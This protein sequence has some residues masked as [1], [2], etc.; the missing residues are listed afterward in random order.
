MFVFKQMAGDG[1]AGRVSCEEFVDCFRRAFHEPSEAQAKLLQEF[2]RQLTGG[3][4]TLDFRKFLI[5]LALVP[6][7]EADSKEPQAE[8][9]EATALPRFEEFVDKY[10]EKMYA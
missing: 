2:F 9:S 4:P 1:A 7:L 3:Q 10:R 8:P 5:G 6:D